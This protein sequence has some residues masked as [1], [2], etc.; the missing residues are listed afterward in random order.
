MNNRKWNLFARIGAGLAGI[1]LTSEAPSGL[2]ATNRVDVP[3][4]IDLTNTFSCGFTTLSNFNLLVTSCSISADSPSV[5][6]EWPGSPCPF[7]QTITLPELSCSGSK[8][9]NPPTA[10]PLVQLPAYA[11]FFEA[12]ARLT[13]PQ[14]LCLGA[15][16]YKQ[17]EISSGS[18][19]LQNGETYQ[20][21]APYS[22]GQVIPLGPDP[23]YTGGDNPQ[24]INFFNHVEDT[25]I[26]GLRFVCSDGPL[27][28][29]A[30]KG[31]INAENY[32]NLPQFS[33]GAM[34]TYMLL[35]PG[36][37]T[38]DINY[39]T[40]SDPA[41]DLIRWPPVQY[42][43]PNLSVCSQQTNDVSVPC[44]GGA[45][46][47]PCGG[48]AIIGTLDMPSETVW[49]QTFFLAAVNGP[50][51]NARTATF[52]GKDFTA[53]NV[54]PS[55]FQGAN[56]DYQL[57]A[58]L[59]FGVGQHYEY[60]ETPLSASV[61][62]YVHANPCE[63]NDVLMT[64]ILC[65]GHIKGNIDL[66]G[67]SYASTPAQSPWNYLT[68]QQTF[69]NG[70]PPQGNANLRRSDTCYVGGVGGAYGG[71]ARTLFEQT[72][73]SANNSTFTGT[74]D[75][76]LAGLSTEA[77]VTVPVPWQSTYLHLNF[78]T[79][80]SL[81]PED[82]LNEQLDITSPDIQNFS[83]NCDLNALQYFDY[84]FGEVLFTIINSNPTDRSYQ[85]ATIS[86]TAAQDGARSVNFTASAQPVVPASGSESIPFRLFLPAGHYENV[87]IRV[88]TALGSYVL[89]PVSFVSSCGTI[90]RVT[91]G[92]V[93]QLDGLPPCNNS[94][95]TAFTVNVFDPPADGDQY[96]LSYSVNGGTPVVA[97]GNNNSCANPLT[98]GNIPL[99]VGV[100]EVSVTVKDTVTGRSTT[101]SKQVY[102]DPNPIQISACGDI[103]VQLAP[104]QSSVEVDYSAKGN[105]L[106]TGGVNPRI[107]TYTIPNLSSF[108]AGSTPVTVTASD[109]CSSA[110]CT[111]QVIVEPGPCTAIITNSLS[112]N[113]N[114]Y[115]G[116]DYHFTVNNYQ[117]TDIAYI[118][119]SALGGCFSVSPYQFVFPSPLGPGGVNPQDGVFT[120]QIFPVCTAR[121]LCLNF[122]AY[123]ANNV[124]VCEF[125]K[126]FAN[127]LFP[128]MPTPSDITVNCRDDSG[129]LVDFVLPS[130]TSV[131]CS[132]VTV[133]PDHPSHSHF[134]IGV[135][136][137]K[138]TAL[139]SCGN[140]TA[141]TF[142]VTVRGHS[143]NQD[144]ARS[145]RHDGV[146]GDVQVSDAIAVDA[147]GFVYIT[148]YYTGSA[149]FGNTQLY[150]FG[151]GKDIFVA[152]FN[153][154]LSGPIWV[155]AAGGSGED[156]ANA[157][158]VDSQGNCYVAGTIDTT[159]W[160]TVNFPMGPVG[161]HL[162]LVRHAAAG[163][164]IFLA[165]YSADGELLWLAQG[166]NNG[167]RGDTAE[168]LAVDASDNVYMC[169]AYHSSVQFSAGDGGFISSA[170]L[171][172]LGANDAYV[173][174]YSPSGNPTWSTST[175]VNSQHNQ[176]GADARSLAVDNTRG[177]VDVVGT[178]TGSLQFGNNNLGPSGLGWGRVFVAQCA[179]PS[180]NANPT[181]NW[182]R[183]TTCPDPNLFCSHD[184]RQLDLDSQGNIY[185]T[186]YFNGKAKLGALSTIKTP[187]PCNQYNDVL[188]GSLNH[189]GGPLWLSALNE[190]CGDD[191]SRAIAVVKD[192]NNP[193]ADGDC[194]VA[195]F[196]SGLDSNA[197]GGRLVMLEH[198]DHSGTKA[199]GN[200]QHIAS[201]SSSIYQNA[202]RGVAV[203][204][205]GCVYVT[206]SFNDSSLNFLDFA[207]P[208]HDPE[209]VLNSQDGQAKTFIAR[210]CPK[211]QECVAPS[212]TDISPAVAIVSF[213]ASGPS[214]T[215]TANLAGHA[216]MRAVWTHL[217]NSGT[218]MLNPLGNS[219]NFN[220]GN[221]SYSVDNR[222]ANGNVNDTG[223]TTTTL[224]VNGWLDNDCATCANK[225]YSLII[226]NDC[227]YYGAP[228]AVAIAQ[229]GYLDRDTA[230]NGWTL[231]LNLPDQ[232]HYTIQYKD[233]LAPNTPWHDLTNGVGNGGLIRVTD[234]VP[235]PT[236]R[237]YRLRIP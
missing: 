125:Q 29:G 98:I 202:G 121:E 189:S 119:A 58:G 181:W 31:S 233:S 53:K 177:V 151:G 226:T 80:D 213:T 26:L 25:A 152:K 91:N 212:V 218:V 190:S 155:Q 237:F 128:T 164:D 153:P 162:Q 216:P 14:P 148:G 188:I 51:G 102:Y 182:A 122:T 67:P 106:V 5:S 222:D 104:G 73:I 236:N 50:F 75:L 101:L 99:Q 201:G 191:E 86:G 192:P 221:S 6:L 55:N 3:A 61:P 111:F 16:L 204:R 229:F 30:I 10:A 154:D 90:T 208:A 42:I 146:P 135:T 130:A 145:L 205:A 19:V 197:D 232:M 38:L 199:L 54:V 71:R 44:P 27:A 180:A 83:M 173:V 20:L 194:Y 35:R 214:A 165:K 138:V 230:N 34:P 48:S 100:N 209:Y 2:A 158:A 56:Q 118:T 84:C 21:S 60:F 77:G 207:N 8:G 186:A 93:F 82:R 198:W 159:V 211:C 57:E 9:F 132:P 109:P 161:P 63:T 234:P 33:S 11:Y 176:Y 195:G 12:M 147:K 79:P 28:P 231:S 168:G 167:Q 169:G 124:I 227:G 62:K 223:P 196:R 110:T 220:Q 65:P 70:G 127:P 107:L 47:I 184:A 105:V 97:C 59:G 235:N 183:Q 178:F 69:Q 103:T 179:I 163:A 141:N 123:N 143:S 78:V 157:I 85:S 15:L 225:P 116:F 32:A 134:P 41:V 52:A 166:F 140:S 150:S 217:G 36:I 120:F 37:S 193:L 40:G 144:E 133:T 1:I 136:P 149:H 219:G 23:N 156:Y 175:R 172:G 43:T 131:C 81:A 66:T 13:Y 224:T 18:V 112:C 39:T 170:T 24:G 87:N 4:E 46:G 187:S 206:G 17:Y 76:R 129:A 92:P 115:N 126:C 200:V 22:I 174:A 215:F 113:S 68:W 171:T 64:M 49:P 88:S 117:N 95:Q 228:L 96:T 72:A 89:P 210:Y 114:V 108:G 45:D 203:D 142:Y 94:P 160:P 7:F 137:V 185:F 139:D 74:Y